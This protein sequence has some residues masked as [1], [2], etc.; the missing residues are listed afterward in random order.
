MAMIE[1]SETS[2]PWPQVRRENDNQH[3]RAN[4]GWR[5]DRS[6]LVYRLHRLELVPLLG[7]DRGLRGLKLELWLR[8]E[9]TR[10]E[11][12]APGTLNMPCSF[13]SLSRIGRESSHDSIA[14]SL[15]FLISSFVLVSWVSQ[16]MENGQAPYPYM[17]EKKLTA[18]GM[19]EYSPSLC[20][21]SAP[22]CASATP[23]VF[24]PRVCFLAVSAE[25]AVALA[26]LRVRL[27][28]ISRLILYLAPG[29]YSR[30]I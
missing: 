25:L 11:G 24:Y 7:V 9:D 4:D 10:H 16:D 1:S 21:S 3:H 27:D 17:L 26:R 28:N 30:V 23:F 6:E 19:H 14:L 22:S 29:C 18:E 5:S 20:K 8:E 12:S 2:W 13:S 15:A